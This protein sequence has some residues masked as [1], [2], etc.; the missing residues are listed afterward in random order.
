[1]YEI[2][3]VVWFVPRKCSA[4]FRIFIGPGFRTGKILE[5]DDLFPATGKRLC[6]F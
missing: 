5:T 1:L 2:L 3:V 4:V 6:D